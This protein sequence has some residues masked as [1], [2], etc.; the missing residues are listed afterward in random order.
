[1][2]IEPR[3]ACSPGVPNNANKEGNVANEGCKNANEDQAITQRKDEKI[4]D[5]AVTINAYKYDCKELALLMMQMHTKYT[6][7]AAITYEI[8]LI[9]KR[10]KTIFILSFPD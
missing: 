3:I 6:N 8:E 5:T 9:Y 7:S 10:L 2:V 4:L 1:M